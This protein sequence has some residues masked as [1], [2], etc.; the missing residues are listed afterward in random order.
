[1]L[2]SWLVCCLLSVVGWLVGW[3]V[4]C[5]IG[6]Y[7]CCGQGYGSDFS[8]CGVV[9]VHSN[10]CCSSFCTFAVEVAPHSISCKNS[11]LFHFIL[12]KKSSY[13]SVFSSSQFSPFCRFCHFKLLLASLLQVIIL[14][15]DI[16][17]CHS[18]LS[19]S[20]VILFVIFF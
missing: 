20:S 9:A 14:Y 17:L 4:G 15:T 7:Q 2:V 10:L 8:R 11:F 3:A 13:H 16:P 12:L 5:L 18:T 19:F 6:W 1:M